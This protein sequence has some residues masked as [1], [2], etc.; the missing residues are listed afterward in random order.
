VFVGG[1]FGE[2]GTG[3]GVSDGAGGVVES[4]VTGTG[5]RSGFCGGVDELPER[6]V[7]GTGIG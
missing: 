4:F 1:T 3:V 7:P 2:G 5:W 6:P